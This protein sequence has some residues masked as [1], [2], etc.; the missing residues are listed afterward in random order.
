MEKKIIEYD[1]QG[2]GSRGSSIILDKNKDING[3]CPHPKLSQYRFKP[4]NIT[5]NEKILEVQMNFI[6][7]H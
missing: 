6:I 3:L 2:G 5:F 1:K 4:N 7:K